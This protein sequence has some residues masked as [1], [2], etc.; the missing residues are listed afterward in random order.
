MKRGDRI[1]LSLVRAFPGRPLRDPGAPP[2]RILVISTTAIG[3]TL[4]GT[5]ALRALKETYPGCRLEVLVQRERRGVLLN[6]PHADELISYRK[7]LIGT[8]RT[9]ARLRRRRYDAVIVFHGNDP[10]IWPLAALTGAPRVIGYARDTR[11]AALLTDPVPWKESLHTV[12]KRLELVRVLGADTADRRLVLRLDEEDHHSAQ[13]FLSAAGISSEAALIA[14]HIGAA[15]AYKCW[16]VERF[17]RVADALAGESGARIVLT[18]G[19]GDVSRMARFEAQARCR[20]LV[21]AGQLGIRGTAALLTRCRLL[22]TNDTGPMHLAFAVGTPTVSLFCP[23]DS[24]TIGPYGYGDRHLAIQ[25][26]KTCV[27]CV[28]K[29]CPDPFC[30]EQISVEEVLAAARGRLGRDAFSPAGR[31]AGASPRG[32]G[33][34]LPGSV[35]GR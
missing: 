4:L 20:P 35:S 15:Q 14:L 28:T 9:A 30:L 26:E 21:A 32:S 19:P 16:P 34:I 23:S 5:P 13:D 8:L 27:R 6:N 18:G 33:T 12:E 10:D 11:F 24:H 7:H 31:E 22:V 3:D 29:R 25:K 17:V 2:A 1:I